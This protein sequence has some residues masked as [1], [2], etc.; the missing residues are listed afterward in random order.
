M[1]QHHHTNSYPAPTRRREKTAHV[2]VLSARAIAWLAQGEP[3]AT[4]VTAGSNAA[5][6][7]HFLRR[8][9]ADVYRERPAPYPAFRRYLLARV[10]LTRAGL[11]S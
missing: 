4:A 9:M 6:T 11:R 10:S 3:A 2:P 1:L 8:E 7:L 5:L